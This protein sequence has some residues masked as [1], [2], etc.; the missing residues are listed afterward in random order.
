MKFNKIILTIILGIV[1]IGVLIFLSSVGIFR[2]AKN[3]AVFGVTPLARLAMGMG[4]TWRSFFGILSREDS[5]KIIRENELLKEKQFMIENLI[6]ENESLRTILDFKKKSNVVLQG[7]G[8]VLY[9]QEFGR[10]FLLIDRG[11]RE[12][13]ALGDS[14]VNF[15]TVFVGAVKETGEDFSKVE[16]A[17]NLG[18]VFE[19]TIVPLG[20]SAIA[21]G[22]G[23][24]AFSI[25]LIPAAAPLR[26]GDFVELAGKKGVSSLL[27]AEIVSVEPAGGAAFQRARATLVAH[28]EL[29]SNVV[30]LLHPSP[31]EVP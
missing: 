9:A 25:E 3:L 7:G 24:R 22:L 19:V 14:V 26:K 31:R 18:T 27:L 4:D 1:L 8:V 11:S 5:E 23:A 13:I 2:A 29:L 6:A 20:I 16:I 15:E 28:P 21:K 17:S 12:G 30:V 10:E